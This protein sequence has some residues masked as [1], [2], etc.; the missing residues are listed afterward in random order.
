[1]GVANHRELAPEALLLELGKPRRHRHAGR[2]RAHAVALHD[3]PQLVGD[4]REV[5]LQALLADQ[6]RVEVVGVVDEAGPL[7]TAG[8]PNGGVLGVLVEDVEV[9][10][11][12]QR[13]GSAMLGVDAA[14]PAKRA[15]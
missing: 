3:P 7:L 9:R 2:R 4:P 11:R 13:R 15:V 12:Q 14:Q 8:G 5:G 1:M 6:S 10:G